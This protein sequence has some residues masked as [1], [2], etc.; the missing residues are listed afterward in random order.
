MTGIG[1]SSIFSSFM[2]LVGGLRC[3]MIL[4]TINVSA[5]LRSR[6]YVSVYDFVYLT[7]YELSIMSINA[8]FVA[9]VSKI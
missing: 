6:L 2:I 9:S 3:S 5:K 1:V 7:C 8:L 4:V